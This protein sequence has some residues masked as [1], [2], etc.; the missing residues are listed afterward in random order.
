MTVNFNI[1]KDVDVSVPPLQ[2]NP[3]WDLLSE[4]NAVA[5]NPRTPVTDAFVNFVAI[6]RT[7]LLEKKAN[8]TPFSELTPKVQDGFPLVPLVIR[9]PAA[10]NSAGGYKVDNYQDGVREVFAKGDVWIELSYPDADLDDKISSSFSDALYIL[11][12]QQ[13]PGRTLIMGS[14]RVLAIQEETPILCS[15]TVGGDQTPF[16]RKHKIMGMDPY[17]NPSGIRLFAAAFFDF[18]EAIYNKYA[19]GP[20]YDPRYLPNGEAIHAT[21]VS[22]F[23]KEG[24][25][26]TN[27]QFISDSIVVFKNLFI[28]IDPDITFT[29]RGE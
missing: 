27:A 4:R 24:S 7:I 18:D 2:T 1:S 19:A 9:T 15:E 13:F 21:V 5:L 17:K 28:N 16:Y 12:S 11:A 29:V 6:D 22:S 20:A 26:Y 3:F 23:K 14:H 8:D 25:S 10:P